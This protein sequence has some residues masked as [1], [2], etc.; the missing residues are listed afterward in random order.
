MCSRDVVSYMAQ[1]QPVAGCLSHYVP[2]RAGIY[3][4]IKLLLLVT[5]SSDLVSLD[6][7][8]EYRGFQAHGHDI[9]GFLYIFLYVAMKDV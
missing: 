8:H 5:V 7:G 1:E 4:A 3:C 6:G 2:K 9:L